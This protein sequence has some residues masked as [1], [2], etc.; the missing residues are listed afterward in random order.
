MVR[1]LPRSRQDPAWFIIMVLNTI[2][3]RH[4]LVLD[5]DLLRFLV[6]YRLG[7]NAWEVNLGVINSGSSY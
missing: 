1:E 2:D 7:I 6:K 4:N 5:L 3:Y